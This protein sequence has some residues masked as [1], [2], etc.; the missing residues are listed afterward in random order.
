[1]ASEYMQ[2]EDRGIKFAIAPSLFIKVLSEL[3][4]EIRKHFI[5]LCKVPNL[6]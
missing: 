2:T 5:G 4:F 6:H 1:M 3:T